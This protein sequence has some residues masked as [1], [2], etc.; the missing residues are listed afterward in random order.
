MNTLLSSTKCKKITNPQSL[1]S[2]YPCPPKGNQPCLLTAVISLPFILSFTGCLRRSLED[3]FPEAQSPCT[4]L[5]SLKRLSVFPGAPCSQAPSPTDGEGPWCC[6]LSLL[7]FSRPAPDLLPWLCCSPLG[8]FSVASSHGVAP[9]S[10]A[11]RGAADV[12][13]LRVS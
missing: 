10:V 13:P 2:P 3:S 4:L 7:V 8:G 11:S 6:E 5:C 1:L 9:S 12:Q